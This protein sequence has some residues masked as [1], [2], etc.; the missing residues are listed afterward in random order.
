MKW[1]RIIHHLDS[2]E[3]EKK[4]QGSSSRR[5]LTLSN[6]ESCFG[7]CENAKAHSYSNISSPIKAINLNR[8]DKTKKEI[9]LK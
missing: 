9:Y 6:K 5:S 7:S 1:T 8:R 2:E 4:S 3:S